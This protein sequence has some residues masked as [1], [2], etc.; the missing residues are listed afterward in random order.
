M[1]K[2]EDLKFSYPQK[3]VL[4]QVSFQVDAGDIFAILGK[5]AAGKT[6]LINIL[7]GLLEAQ[8]G[9][10]SISG[11]DVTHDFGQHIR[12]KIGVMRPITGVFLKMRVFQYFEFVAGLYGLNDN[13]IIL[14]LANKYELTREL[15]SKI[16]NCSTGTIKKIELGA[17]ILHS[18]DVLFLDEPFESIDP[19]V[20]AE[21]KSYL[22]Y[23][24]SKGKSVIITS[25]ILDIVQNLCN[26]CMILNKGLVVYNDKI[27]NKTKL[28]K[29][30]L[31]TVEDYE[32]S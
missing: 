20:S 31:E 30:F 24:S 1:L 9:K 3:E 2:V 7:T 17:A 5:N 4:E 6:T 13:K 12:M 16:K 25:H 21:I 19:V 18:P 27:D 23:I 11:E 26:K 22:K 14:D 15:N 29:I 8:D 10:I 32:K 28:E